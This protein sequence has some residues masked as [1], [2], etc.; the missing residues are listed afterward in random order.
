[1]AKSQ[2]LFDAV[3]RPIEEDTRMPDGRW[4]A[5][6]TSYD[7]LGRKTAV[8][9]PG[10]PGRVTQYLGYDAFGR[11]GTIRPPDSTLANGFVHDVTLSYGGVQTVTR[12]VRVGSGWNGSTV[13]ESPSTTT[14]T[15]DRFGRLTAVAEP[16]GGSGANV[17]TAYGYD[18]GGQLINVTTW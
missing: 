3:G 11:P 13:T 8:S 16:S 15:Y 1:L 12:T 6:T 7:A 4:S 17:T 9:E 14:E 10:S 5:R 18:T 2:T